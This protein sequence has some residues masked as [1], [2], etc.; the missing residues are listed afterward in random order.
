[1]QAIKPIASTVLT[2]AGS[3]LG[4]PPPIAAIGANLAVGAADA[5]ASSVAPL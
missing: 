1:M 4:I 5:V 2:V 3:A